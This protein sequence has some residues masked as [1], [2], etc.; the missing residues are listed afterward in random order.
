MAKHRHTSEI[1]QEL[2]KAAGDEILVS[3]T[4]HL[5]PLKRGIF[6]TVYLNLREGVTAAD[7]AAA[8]EKAYAHEP[9]VT[10]MEAGKAIQNMNLMFGLKE[11]SGLPTAGLYL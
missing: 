10:V 7:V 4:P 11:T 3:F 9:F 5:A 6:A 1:E 2:S 8:Y